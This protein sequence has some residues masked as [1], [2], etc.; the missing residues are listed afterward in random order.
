MASRR[1]VLLLSI[2]LC[3]AAAPVQADNLNLRSVGQEPPNNPQGVPRPARGMTMNQVRKMFGE[4]KQILPAV[5]DPPITRWVYGE[6]T[7]YF[8][9]KY[10]IHSVVHP[11]KTNK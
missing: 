4:P 3:I 11:T 6:Y 7:V 2:L 5:G 1:L 9:Y 10:V 8:E